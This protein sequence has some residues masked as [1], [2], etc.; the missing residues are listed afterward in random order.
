MKDVNYAVNITCLREMLWMCGYV[1]LSER[2]V[3][4][5]SEVNVRSTFD[6]GEGGKRLVE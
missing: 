4:K 5:R 1:N 2:M 3:S 6:C